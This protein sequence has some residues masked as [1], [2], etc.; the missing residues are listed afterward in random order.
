[1][2]KQYVKFISETNIEFAPLNKG[3]ILNYDSESNKDMLLADG[4]KEL[5][6]VEEPDT[7]RHYTIEYTE[8]EETINETIKFLE[9]EEEYQY[10]KKSEKTKEET[11]PINAE[12]NDLDLKRIRAVCEPS[13]KDETTGQTWLDYYNSLILEKRNQLKEIYEKAGADDDITQ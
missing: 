2:E 4:Y 5:I 10:R 3:N 7:D 6:P 1:M 11:D 9:T 13:I 12:L 8:N